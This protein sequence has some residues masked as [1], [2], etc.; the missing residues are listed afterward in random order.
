M[1]VAYGGG[2]TRCAASRLSVSVASGVAMD[3]GECVYISV[4]VYCSML[5]CV[6]VCCSVLRCIEILLLYYVSVASGVAMDV[7]EC[8]YVC[9]AVCCSMLQCVAVY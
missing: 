3:V 1:L 4:A 9:V 2:A 5:Q 6:A 8:V 7:G